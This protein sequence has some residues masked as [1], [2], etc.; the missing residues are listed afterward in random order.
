[1]TDLLLVGIGGYGHFYLQALLHEPVDPDVRF[2]GAVDP[3][4]AA[5]PHYADVLAAGVPIYERLDEFY[6]G[7]QADLAVIAAPIHLHAPQTLMALAHGSHVL[8]EKPVAATLQDARRMAEAADQAGKFVAVGYQWSFSATMQALKADIQAGVLGRPQRLK[9]YVL[10]PRG[11]SYFDRNRWAARIRSDDGA[12]VLDSPVNNA[13]AHYLHNMLYVLGQS[14]ATTAQPANIQA[15]LYRANP[16]ENYDTAALRIVTEEGVEILFYTS[17]AVP[18]NDGPAFRYEFEEAVVEYGSASGSLSTAGPVIA[19]FRDGRQ[20]NYGDPFA[21]SANKL[22]QSAGA[23]RTGAAR[24]GAA[25]VCDV[26]T[27]MAHTLC[28]NGAQESSAIVTLP[29]RLVRQ[30]G[31]VRWVDG[32]AEVLHRG[33]A[34]NALPS[35][36]D[37]VPWSNRGV[38]IDLRTMTHFPLRD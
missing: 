9:S 36:L 13:A 37:D 30:T 8:C 17:H 33:F 38:T 34:E 27:A 3:F 7:H 4:A 5:S 15:E 35:E 21:D 12:W 14:R 1:M 11:A 19:T 29:E 2:V 22:W 20:K 16:I 24:T 26:R 32:L 28:V 6:A 18:Q 10:W 25:V 23:A 31:D